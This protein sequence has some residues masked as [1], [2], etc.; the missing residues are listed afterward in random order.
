[1]R[2]IRR[3]GEAQDATCAGFTSEPTTPMMAPS[4]YPV[5]CTA[6]LCLSRNGPARHPNAIR[7]QDDLRTNAHNSSH[8]VRCTTQMPVMKKK[9]LPTNTLGRVCC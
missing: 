6:E 9:S 8:I 7:R 2:L 3:R 1:M 4:L 5:K